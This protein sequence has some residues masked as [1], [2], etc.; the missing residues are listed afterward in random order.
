MGSLSKV[1]ESFGKIWRNTWS[2]TGVIWS[3]NPGKQKT[4]IDP[5]IVPTIDPVVVKAISQ[6]V[7]TKPRTECMV[8]FP[9]P[10][11]S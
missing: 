10:N 7:S 2:K 3:A 11:T 1:R 6:L 4:N 9:S 8:N 5:I